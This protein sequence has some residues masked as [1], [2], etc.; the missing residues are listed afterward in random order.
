MTKKNWQAPAVETLEISETMAGF[1][2]QY[3]DYVFADKDLDIT[4]KADPGSVIVGP[5]PSV[6]TPS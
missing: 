3:I 2:S 5:A 4:D 6:P 1:G